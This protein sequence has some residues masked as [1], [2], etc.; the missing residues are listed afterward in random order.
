LRD[1]II[2]LERREYYIA[3][4]HIR[5]IITEEINGEGLELDI[6]DTLFLMNKNLIFDAQYPFSDSNML[7]H[8]IH[9]PSIITNC[10]LII[11]DNNVNDA[12][13]ANITALLVCS[14]SVT[15]DTI[16]HL[17]LLLNN[18]KIRSIELMANSSVNYAIAKKIFFVNPRITFILCYDANSEDSFFLDDI[19][20]CIVKSTIPFSDLFIQKIKPR[21]FVCNIP[22][23]N[24]SMSV[25]PFYYKKLHIDSSGRVYDNFIS[26]NVIGKLTSK[27]SILEIISSTACCEY[28]TVS[29]EFIDVCK[30][31]EFRNICP[32]NR[33]PQKRKD[34][35]WYHDSECDYNPYIAKWIGEEGYHTL[36]SK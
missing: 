13:L 29:K 33:I 7:D 25:N 31:C 14:Q 18:T 34:G 21:H 16:S 19:K 9:C 20:I 8:T 17:F 30:H 4:K 32:D 5:D 26:N 24:D 12:L 2:D 6:D 11:E 27:N 23:Y 3:P 1:T 15:E 28:S 35:S 22:F 36:S 10:T